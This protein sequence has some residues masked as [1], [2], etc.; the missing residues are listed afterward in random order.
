MKMDIDLSFRPRRYFRPERLENHV[1]SQV[2]N[3]VLRRELKALFA[4]GRHAEIR[5]LAGDTRLSDQDR[6]VLASIHP[7]LMG[8]SYLPVLEDFEVEIAR[9]SIK[10]TTY[11]VTCVYARL[12]DGLIHYRVVDEYGGDTLRAPSE[13]RSA[14][15]MTLGELTDFFL[16]AW[17]LVAVLEMNFDN[18]LDAALGFFSC[19]SEFYPDFHSLCVQ[20]VIQHFD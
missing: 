2:R 13:A 5:D 19:D 8:G 7:V 15:P 11:D 9:I 3:T 6:A 10:S 12:E 1:I 17:R 20:R 16:T 4:A 18:N 14:L